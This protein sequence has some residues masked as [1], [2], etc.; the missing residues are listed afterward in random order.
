M[1]WNKKFLTC[2]TDRLTDCLTDC[3]GLHVV[4]V[5]LH[6]SVCECELLLLSQGPELLDFRGA[7]LPLLPGARDYYGRWGPP[8]YLPALD[9]YSGIVPF[10]APPL[11][12]SQPPPLPLPPPPLPA[13]EALPPPPLPPEELPPPPPP[14]DWLFNSDARADAPAASGA[15]DNRPRISDI[16]RF[17]H[18]ARARQEASSES[19]APAAALNSLPP[20]TLAV[21]DRSS[22]SLP[23]A[24]QVFSPERPPKAAAAL[25][26]S[27]PPG[28]ELGSEISVSAYSP[29]QSLSASTPQKAVVA[30]TEDDDEDDEDELRAQLLRAL[31]ARRR[32]Q[33]E[34]SP[35]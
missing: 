35:Q 33:A 27:S 12:P 11:P 7:D 24:A 19:E 6:G 16:A 15:R 23:A 8:A 4:C 26:S 32:E 25:S 9:L 10:M 20:Q 29:S 34:V 18:E 3:A 1:L 13:E 17:V 28:E 30:S 2:L 21:S 5:F 22:P 31:A 14:P